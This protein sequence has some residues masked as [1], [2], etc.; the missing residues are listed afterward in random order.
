MKCLNA[1]R[2][3]EAAIH[4]IKKTGRFAEATYLMVWCSAVQSLFVI[5]IEVRGIWEEVLKKLSVRL[6]YRSTA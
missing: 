3:L 4:S 5:A 2:M 1:A 6:I